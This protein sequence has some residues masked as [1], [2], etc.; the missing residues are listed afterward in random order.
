MQL[1][2]L[3]ENVVHVSPRVEDVQD[4]VL[5]HMMDGRESNEFVMPLLLLLLNCGHS[6]YLMLEEEVDLVIAM[7]GESKRDL[8]LHDTV[9]GLLHYPGCHVPWQRYHQLATVPPTDTAT[10][11]FR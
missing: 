9:D 11:A 1:E 5:Q 7:I 6:L 3:G 4:L 2:E 10:T 8:H